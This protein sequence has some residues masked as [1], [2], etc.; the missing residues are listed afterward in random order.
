MHEYGSYCL[1]IYDYSVLTHSRGAEENPGHQAKSGP[2]PYQQIPDPQSK[3]FHHPNITKH[4][5]IHTL[6]GC[7]IYLTTR[8]GGQQMCGGRR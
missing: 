3:R 1:F 2:R 6:T 5:I 4:P 8:P 7:H